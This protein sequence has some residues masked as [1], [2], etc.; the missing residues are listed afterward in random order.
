MSFL[1]GLFNRSLSKPVD[2]S[3]LQTDFH[4]HLIP[5][6]DDG[7]ATMEDSLEVIRK[8]KELGYRKL[9]TT[10]HVM[11]D[12]FKNDNDII[13]RG[14]D[15][16]RE[17]IAQNNI[18][19]QFEAAAEYYADEHLED[20]I[21]KKDLLTFGNGYVL[22]ELSFLMEPPNLAKL[23]FDMQ[24]AGYKPILAHPERYQYWHKRWDKYQELRDKGVGLQMNMLS[25]TG[26]YSPQIKKAAQKMLDEDL[27][28][29]TGSDCHRIQ[30]LQI[31]EHD[32]TNPYF[33]KLVDVARNAELT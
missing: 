10:P 9:I 29:F 16:V 7:V 32:L 31:L 13:T 22:F 14:A 2:L 15:K 33:Q 23:I 1:K 6:I 25:L 30:H 26:H 19:M 21:Q 17:A 18:D 11:T 4:S 12:Y 20:L 8:F 5:G 3:V 24:M 27:V 28:D